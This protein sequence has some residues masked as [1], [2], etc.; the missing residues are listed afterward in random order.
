MGLRRFHVFRARAEL[1]DAIP[2]PPRTLTVA[3]A[4]CRHVRLCVDRESLSV[5][6]GLHAECKVPS[7]A[8]EMQTVGRIPCFYFKITASR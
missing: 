6:P 5:L 7:A 2:H 1:G 3:M 8:R 4:C